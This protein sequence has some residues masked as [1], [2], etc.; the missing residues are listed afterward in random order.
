MIDQVRSSLN[1]LLRRA[2]S[3]VRRLRGL[4]PLAVALVLILAAAAVLGTIALAHGG[5]QAAATS[6]LLIARADF[7]SETPYNGK[8][9][10]MNAALSQV[11]SDCQ[12]TLKGGYCLRYTVV[13]DEQAVMVGYGVIPASAV[14]VTSSSIVINV[15]TNK[16]AHFVHV[17]GV[18]S[19]V[20]I[21]WKFAS[22]AGKSPSAMI[23]K[24]QKA[25]AL[26]GIST[27][28][29]PASAVIA[30]VLYK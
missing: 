25:T 30:T 20:S 19:P 27:Y 6:P 15:D 21:S 17:V 7:H 2:P 11:G 1:T 18:G 16:V 8:D 24:P 5:T 29:V 28:T 13:L 26:G 10:E 12:A 23:N 9:L 22:T 4:A 3:G 14:Q